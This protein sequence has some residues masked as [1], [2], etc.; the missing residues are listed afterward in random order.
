MKTLKILACLAALAAIALP[1]AAQQGAPDHPVFSLG[2]G[3]QYWHAKDLDY[4]DED[5]MWGVNLIARIR[6]SAYFAIDL[7]AGASGVWDAEKYRVDGEKYKTDVTFSCYPVEAGLLL[8]LPVG[9]I[10]TFYGG[11]G[12]GYYNYD[13]DIETSAKHGHHYD[14]KYHEHVKVDD[15]FGWYAVG[16]VNFSVARCLSLFGEVRYTGTETKLKED[17]SE[18]IDCSGIGGQIGILFDF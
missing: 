15:D 18:K 6:P 4:F 17:K 12:G 14:S 7:R 9:D 11:G 16:G 8:M 5:G 13:I 1:A 3:G 10:V 2:F